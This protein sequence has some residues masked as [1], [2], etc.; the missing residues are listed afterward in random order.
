VLV[1]R[2]AAREAAGVDDQLSFVAELGIAAGKRVGV[3]Q[4]GR[5]VAVDLTRGR[6]PVGAQVERVRLRGDGG[7]RSPPL[8]LLDGC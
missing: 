3:E 7:D 4:R 2:R 5:R 1:L 8:G 6:D